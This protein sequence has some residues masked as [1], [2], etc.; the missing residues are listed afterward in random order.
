MLSWVVIDRLRPRRNH[1]PA[2]LSCPSP[3]M[4]SLFSSA[5]KLPSLQLLSF[6]ILTNARGCGGHFFHHY[7][8]PTA[9]YP[10]SSISFLFKLFRTLLRFLHFRKIQL[11]CFQA[12]P[13]SLRKTPGGGGHCYSR[14]LRAS[15]RGGH[16]FQ[17]KNLSLPS[18]LAILYSPY[19][20]PAWH[21]SPTV[22]FYR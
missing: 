20:R 15:R 3:E 21:P 1:H 7:L 11:F 17:A 2:L 19:L 16:I 12:I 18:S 5:Y 13:H 6:D 4:A 9:H 14:A 8:L 10:L 22:L